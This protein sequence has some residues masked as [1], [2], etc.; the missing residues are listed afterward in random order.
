MPSR[1]PSSVDRHQ[2]AAVRDVVDDAV[3][4]QRRRADALVRPVVGAPGGQLVVH[5]LPQELAVGL[6]ERHQDAL[7]P[8]DVR[9]PCS[10]LVVGA[11]EHHAA[12]DDRVAVG[13]RAELGHPLDVLLGL[14]VPG[15]RQALHAR[16]HVAVGRAA[17][18]RPV[19]VGRVG[20]R[21]PARARRATAS[22][23][24]SECVFLHDVACLMPRP[25]PMRGSSSVAQTRRGS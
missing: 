16:H 22:A 10:A 7:V 4:D 3:L 2:L 6:A 23:A 1:K 12:G 9:D 11:D 25:E 8:L 14:D 19:G 13:L 24:I 17:P 15:G 21:E 20:A 5:R 18:H